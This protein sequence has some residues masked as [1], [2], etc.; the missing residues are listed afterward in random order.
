L[1]SSSFFPLTAFLLIVS[2]LIS[3]FIL[4]ISYTYE[5][6]CP[7]CQGKGIVTCETCGGS[8]KCWICEG[9]GIIDYMPPGS[10]WCAACQGT[11][12][13][14]TC[15]GS[16]LHA[17][18]ECRGTGLLIHWMYTPAGSTIVLSIIGIFL[19]LGSF[20]LGGFLSAFYLSFNEWIYKVED[21][22][23]WFNPSFLTWLFAK[24]RERWAKWQTGASLFFAVY[25]GILLFW[26]SS[27]EAITQETFMTGA[28]FSTVVVGLF[29]L[30]FYK[31]YISRLEASP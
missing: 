20:V 17:C 29:S 27:L 22:G 4:P 9:D 8:G 10:Q 2:L 12:R 18:G 19:F 15:G 5:E 30:V 6:I 7:K 14:Y 25:L 28:L 23:F 3:L 24:H 31:L 26:I 16:G 11:G 13:C 21:M 1:R